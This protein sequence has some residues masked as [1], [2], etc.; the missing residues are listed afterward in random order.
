MDKEQAFRAS[1]QTFQ[2]ATPTRLGIVAERDGVV[3]LSS[4]EKSVTIV[5]YN[6]TDLV[7]VRGAIDRLLG[8]PGIFSLQGLH[9]IANPET[10]GDK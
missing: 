2:H 4:W 10:K 3:L 5:L 9:A 7:R 8:V 1:R 6:K